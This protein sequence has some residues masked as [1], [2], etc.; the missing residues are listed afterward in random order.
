MIYPQLWS[1]DV[2]DRIRANAVNLDRQ[3]RSPGPVQMCVRCVVTNQRPRIVFDAEGVCSAC[4]HHERKYDGSID[5]EGRRRQLTELVDKHSKKGGYDVIVPASGGKDSSFAAWTLRDMGMR[6]LLARWAPNVSTDIG[7]RNW[8]ALLHSG[9]DGVTA[10]PNGL[11]HRKLSR[12]ALEFYGD[13]FLPFIFGQLAWPF[14]VAVQNNVNFVFFGENGEAEYGGDPSAN[15]RRCWNNADWERVYLKGANARRLL[16][17]GEQLGAMTKEECAAISPFYTLPIVDDR[18]QFH[19]L[20]YYMPWHPQQNFYHAAQNTGFE[21]CEHRSEGTFSRYASIDDKLDG[22]H[23]RMAYVKFG[24][25]RCTSDA[26]QEVR[27][28]LLTRDE[29]MA[30]VA[31]YDGEM[32][33]RHLPECLDYL[34]LNPEQYARIEERFRK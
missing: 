26:A 20:G 15:D 33:E 18:P 32:P 1:R 13:N 27:N 24:I 12:L 19:W 10:Q 23:Y 14:H 34:G 8:Q 16:H 17:A 25:G 28:G 4:R 21:P 11:L 30:L 6:P 31:K 5:W 2:E 22:L 3:E 7:E 29:A 9:F